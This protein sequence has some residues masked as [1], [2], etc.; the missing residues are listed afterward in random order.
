M[1]NKILSAFAIALVV[2]SGLLP[3]CS[4]GLSV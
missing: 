4:D 2:A 1:K 3:G